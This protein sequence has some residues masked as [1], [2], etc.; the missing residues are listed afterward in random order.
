MAA[1]APSAFPAWG[2]PGAGVPGVL[3]G[4]SPRGHAIHAPPLRPVTVIGPTGSGKT[5]RVTAPILAEWP[6]PAV[7]LSVRTDL[8]GLAHPARS[9]RGPVW[10]VDPEGALP[11]GVAAARFDLTAW[12]TSLA[13]AQ[14]VAA[15][16]LDSAG[17]DGSRGGRFWAELAQSWT[18]PILFAGARSGLDIGEIAD[19]AMQDRSTR[20]ERLVAQCGDPIAIRML[21]SVADLE[22]R[23][24]TS[25]MATV[26]QA[27]RVFNRAGV[28]R[29]TTGSDFTLDRVLDESATLVLA[30]PAFRMRQVA[31]LFAALLTALWARVQARA[32]RVAPSR[33]PLLLL[34][35]EA[36]HV[37]GVTAPVL[38][39]VTTGPGLG[40]QVV[41]AWHDLAQLTARYGAERSTLVNNSGSVL[42]LAAGSDPD[43]REFLE[44]YAA[45]SGAEGASVHEQL[46]VT[47]NLVFTAGRCEPLQLREPV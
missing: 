6:G 12:V 4:R 15:V 2:T 32:A 41:T 8:I 43:G 9:R 27:L 5:T 14:D 13:D 46:E 24:R 23:A 25:V 36:A 31:P 26:C 16:L 17:P 38:E 22:A 29:A 20:A 3:L 47:G 33:P 11:A 45:A 35:D 28:V 7:V 10:L 42:F 40:V 37:P 21:R 18:A 19:L 1:G 30:L 34:V 44:R 39:W